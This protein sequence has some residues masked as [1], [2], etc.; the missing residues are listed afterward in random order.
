LKT[1]LHCSTHQFKERHFAIEVSTDRLKLELENSVPIGNTYYYLCCVV[2]PIKKMCFINFNWPIKFVRNQSIY[3]HL[4]KL[5][6][7]RSYQYYLSNI[8]ISNYLSTLLFKIKFSILFQSF[9]T[10]WDIDWNG[11]S[12]CRS[13]LNNFSEIR[14]FNFNLG[15]QIEK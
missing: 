5:L 12:S 3:F 15:S 8:I 14:P 6:L 11:S 13:F 7:R 1:F 2:K 4:K 9:E 10:S